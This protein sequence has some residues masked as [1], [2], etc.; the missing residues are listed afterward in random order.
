MDGIWRK[1]SSRIELDNSG[2]ETGIVSTNVYD[3]LDRVIK[4]LYAEG[5]SRVTIY[6]AKGQIERVT[7]PDGVTTLYEYNAKGDISYY[8]TDMDQ[9]GVLDK[10]ERDRVTLTTQSYT[11]NY[12]GDVS[13]TRAF[14]IME[15]DS[16]EET[17]ISLAQNSTDGLQ[18]W[19]IQNNLTNRQIIYYAGNGIRYLTNTAPD[20]TYVVQKFEH[21]N[22]LSTTKNDS[23]G[24]Q[25][26]QTVNAYDAHGRLVTSTDA[27]TA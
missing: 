26:S 1:Y 19:R 7:D 25:L 9:D 24:T 14:V 13:E 10:T 16:D 12:A 2:N 5:A 27:R 3:M 6:N 23:T 15:F 21:G 11:N 22:L 17:L 8:A 4:V 20:G 18:S